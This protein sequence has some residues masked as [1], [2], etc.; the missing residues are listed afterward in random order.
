MWLYQFRFLFLSPV[1]RDRT[2]AEKMCSSTGQMFTF[3]CLFV[4]IRFNTR[5]HPTIDSMLSAASLSLFLSIWR[6]RSFKQQPRTNWWRLRS[7]TICKSSDSKNSIFIFLSNFQFFSRHIMFISTQRVCV[8]IV[9]LVRVFVGFHFLSAEY[10]HS[11]TQH[12]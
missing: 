12:M 2:R 9:Q 5:A 3:D 10:R 4:T 11:S 8:N 1:A 7:R 6:L